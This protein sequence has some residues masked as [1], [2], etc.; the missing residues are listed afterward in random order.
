MD[1]LQVKARDMWLERIGAKIEAMSDAQKDERCET[2][3]RKATSYRE[4]L[5]AVRAGTEEG[6]R[7][8]VMWYR[9]HEQLLEREIQRWLREKEAVF[10]SDPKVDVPFFANSTRELS[11]RDML[12]EVKN[13]TDFGK[14]MA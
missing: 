14:K 13:R 2:L 6:L 7:I 3:F 1:E 8:A 12:N 5:E 9:A 11:M 4:T 10:E